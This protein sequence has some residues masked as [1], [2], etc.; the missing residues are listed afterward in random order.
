[1]NAQLDVENAAGE[2]L[3]AFFAG[4][5]VTLGRCEPATIAVR[6][7]RTTRLLLHAELRGRLKRSVGAGDG[8]H[9]LNSAR[10]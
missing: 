6:L 2:L 9:S 4:A 10:Q 1:V 3:R 5:D 7:S 8:S